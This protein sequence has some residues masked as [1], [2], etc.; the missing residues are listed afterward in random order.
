MK[1][2]GLGGHDDEIDDQMTDE[3]SCRNSG[4]PET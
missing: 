3:K 1:L 4:L 2:E